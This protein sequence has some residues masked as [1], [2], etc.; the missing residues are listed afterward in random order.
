[1]VKK[2]PANAKDVG[3]ICGSERSSEKEL[4]THSSILA[5]RVPQT[6]EPG[7]LQSMQL[8]KSGTQLSDST[9]AVLIQHLRPDSQLT[10]GRPVLSSGVTAWPGVSG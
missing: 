5:W 10:E 7:G 3:S 9:T 1:M 2:Q 8:Q 6:E 4:A